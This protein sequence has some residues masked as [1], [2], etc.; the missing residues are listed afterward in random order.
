MHIHRYMYKNLG[1]W[2]QIEE[3]N[4][5]EKE[6]FAVLICFYLHALNCFQSYMKAKSAVW[7]I[8]VLM[9]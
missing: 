5:L 7:L 2:Q 9:L 1:M 8:P 4:S 3:K 6:G